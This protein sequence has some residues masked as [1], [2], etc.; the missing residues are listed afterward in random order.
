[1]YDFLSENLRADTKKYLYLLKN[2][3]M[4]HSFIMMIITLVCSVSLPAQKIKYESSFEKAKSLAFQQNKPLAILLTIQAPEFS[5]DFMKGLKDERVI[6]KFNSSFINYIADRADTA[7]SGKIIKEFRI[8]RFPSYIFL[9]S[10]GGF[11]FTDAAILT[12]PELLLE[13]ARKAL[14]A[15]G[16]KSLV[17]YDSVY[18]SGDYSTEFIKEYIL[19]RE[20]AG[21]TS[22]ADLI[23]K[24]VLRLKVSDF[25]K[26]DEVLFILKAGPT[27]DGNAYKLACLNRQLIDS[28]Y[29]TEPLADRKVMNNVIITNTMSSAIAGKNV[30]RA[31]SAANFAQ[32]SWKDNYNEGNKV[33]S[34]KMMQY[35]KAVNDTTNYLQL[36]FGFYER[37]YMT[38]TLDSVRKIDSLKFVDARNNA[39]FIS[40]QNINDSTIR[41]TFRFSFTKDSFATDLNNA[42]WTF[43]QMVVNKNEYLQKAMM[44]SRRSIE[45]SPKPAFYDTYAHLLY[46][47]KFFYE[48]ESMELKAIETG[49]A[50]KT[51]VKQFQ[52]EYEKIKKRTL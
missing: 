27:V 41:H 1:M 26:Y 18:A 39:R 4:K 24:Y 44:W 40:T 5:P 8:I 21:I 35:Y 23:E 7:A 15:S 30:N 17:D 50:E 31:R 6:E 37:Y 29:T 28:I 2:F 11:L 9:D 22:N 51:D 13:T 25:Y 33:W 47:L 49:K 48:A 3:L 16:E 38:F 19:R 12:V 36:V 20:S 52:E 46:R 45:M 43:Y 14:K 32:S 42:A 34:M 10:K